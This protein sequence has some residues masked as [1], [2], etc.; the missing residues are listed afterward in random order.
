MSQ[1]QPPK[2]RDILAGLRRD[3]GVG[4]PVLIKVTQTVADNLTANELTTLAVP[5]V[6]L[7]DLPSELAFCDCIVLHK[8]PQAVTVSLGR[9]RDCDIVVADASVSKHHATLELD[10]FNG[11]FFLTDLGS[12]NGTFVNGTRVGSGHRTP[13]GTLSRISLGKAVFVFVDG[14]TMKQLSRIASS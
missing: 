10:T 12:R 7:H 3:G 4:A 11:E 14:S 2:L 1:P 8:S 13:V 9:S 5:V 6:G